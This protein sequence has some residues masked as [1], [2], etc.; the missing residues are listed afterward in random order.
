LVEANLGDTAKEYLGG[1]AEGEGVDAEGIAV[2]DAADLEEG[3]VE[4]AGGRDCGRTAGEEE[5]GAKRQ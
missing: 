2:V 1:E 4:P 3:K 5:D